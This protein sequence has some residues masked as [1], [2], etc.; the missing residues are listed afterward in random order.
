MEQSWEQ[1]DNRDH[2]ARQARL[3]LAAIVESSDD[4]IIGKDLN[5]II[6]DW[7][8][9][10]E[11]LYGYSADET[12][13]KPISIIVP[14]GPVDDVVEIMAKIRAGE[15][16]KHFET[17]RRK[18]DGTLVEV[19]LTVSPI[20][21][22]ERRIIGV[23]T[24]ARD[25]S[26][27]KHQEAAL[28]ESEEALRQKDR[29]LSETRR[30]ARVGS[31]YC[32]A[33]SGSVTWS[34]ELYRIAGLDPSLPAPTHKDEPRHF[35]AESWEQLQ[36]PVQEAL[37]NGTPYELD[38]EMV[39]PDGT[40][41]WVKAHG[42]PVSD[43]AG[44]IVALRGAAQ[45]ITELK[46]AEEAVAGMSHKLLEAQEQ[47]RIR[48]G[49]ELHDDVNQRLALLSVEIQ[50]VK[51]VSPITYG[52]LRSRMDELGK[53]TSE[54]SAVVQF[55]SHELHSS[56]LEY[57]GLVSAMRGFCKEFGDKHEVE[58]VFA[59]EGMPPILPPEL[60]LCL[61]R[62]TQE[63]LRNALKHSG[64][65]LFEVKLHGSP[66]DI[67]LT[68]RDSGVGFDP[69]LIKDTQGLGLISMQERVRLA[70]GTISITSRPQSGTE[71]SVRVPLSART[72][73]ESIKSEG[74]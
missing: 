3:R 38:L 7:N 26:E 71:I 15:T 13:G 48:I 9:G 53:R 6:T 49:R 29:E 47:E 12:I 61:I 45:D 21:D 40:T 62:V 74:A 11:R 42:E 41:R 28:R 64:V 35:A 8:K 25:I 39:R 63:G 67:R 60:S 43:T 1:T 2:A 31:F 69:E 55:L 32:D 14:S 33:R 70:K 66:T 27:R 65:K 58:V 19:S 4:A 51:E 20:L 46:L 36:A 5:G 54:I 10:A 34:E 72:P 56:R 59:S 73:N 22:T 24:I 16:I 37:R 18:K 30:F 44:R 52:E 57:L 50:R 17:V 68:V 23:S